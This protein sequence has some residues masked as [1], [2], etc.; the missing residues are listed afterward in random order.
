MNQ[1][2]KKNI[3]YVISFIN[4]SIAFEWIAENL[5]KDKYNLS[6]ILLN[7][8]DTE[9]ERYLRK[10]KIPVERV[11]YTGKKNYLSALRSLYKILKRD[12]IDVVHA[13]LFDANVVGII[14]AFFA[15]VKKRIHTRHH[16]TW[17]HVHYPHAVYYDKLVNKLST[18][19]IAISKNLENVLVEKDKANPEKIT[20][21]HHGF[22]LEQFENI[23]EERIDLLRK[24]YNPNNN[25]PVF[26]VIG[27]YIDFKGIQF[28]VPAFQELLKFYPNAILI[29][30]NGVGKHGVVIKKQLEN[31]PQKNYIEVTFEKDI[32]AFYRLFTVFIH[33][34]IDIDSEA[35][36][37]TYVESLASEIPSVFT[38]AG[39]AD[40]F[41]EDHKNA[42]VVP[43]ENSESTVKAVREMMENPDLRKKL[44]EQGKKDVWSLFK[45][46]T[47]IEKLENIYDR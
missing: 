32:F 43:F 27:R 29:L 16:G 21:I 9:L 25:Y 44:S 20:L 31:I 40:E 34:P 17:H 18:D 13:H 4:K 15:G 39:V 33:T 28:V 35:F 8:V 7:S 38:L 12:K 42:L 6:F 30:A 47:M 3:C 22:K 41:I 36:G 11:Y 45:L 14:A 26:G 24:K 46:S 10:N 2:N 19:I 23:S 1:L 5:S 37:Q